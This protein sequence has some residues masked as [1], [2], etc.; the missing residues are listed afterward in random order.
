[1]FYLR[2]PECNKKEPA[3]GSRFLFSFHKVLQVEPR[4]F[5]IMNN[6]VKRIVEQIVIVF[7]IFNFSCISSTCR[8]SSCTVC[9]SSDSRKWFSRCSGSSALM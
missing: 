4:I 9:I 8:F 5:G 6:L 3:W 7:Q 2:C 1:M